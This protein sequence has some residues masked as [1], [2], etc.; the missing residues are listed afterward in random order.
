MI[1]EFICS[2]CD[3]CAINNH[4]P[5][6]GD[7]NLNANMMFITRNPSA[8]EFKRNIP[9]ISKDGLLFQRYLDLFNF[10]R[11]LVFIT[12]SIKCK[13]PGHRYPSDTE[14]YNCRE[15]LDNEI[16]HVNPKIIVLLGDT[17]LRSYFKLAFTDKNVHAENLNGK[18]MVHNN[19][20]ILFMINPMQ[21]VNSSAKR[22]D[23]YNAFLSLLSLYRVVNPA[24][25]I[26]FNLY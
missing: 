25:T 11:D 8:L 20:V 26:N 12:N 7:G 15:Y 24:H 17:A 4:R 18:Y 23:L 10:S 19:R 16:R 3:I 13:T 22:V 14:L 1:T 9:M 5:V 6:I 21:A 2:K